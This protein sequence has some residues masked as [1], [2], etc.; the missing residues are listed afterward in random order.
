[1]YVCVCLHNL[2]F[3]TCYNDY[4]N[5][6]F[7]ITGPRYSVLQHWRLPKIMLLKHFMP[8]HKRMTSLFNISTVCFLS[9]FLTSVLLLYSFPVAFAANFVIFLINVLHCRS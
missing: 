6:S 7:L 8:F 1:V 9:L 4:I 5:N 2:P 3:N